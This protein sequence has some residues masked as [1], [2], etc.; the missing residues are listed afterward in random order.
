M[1]APLTPPASCAA[2]LD[3]LRGKL[4]DRPARLVGG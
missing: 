1:R 3:G 4:S 2:W